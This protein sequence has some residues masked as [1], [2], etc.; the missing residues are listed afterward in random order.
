MTGGLG[1][2]FRKLDFLEVDARALD[3]DEAASVAGIS[4]I[5]S[6]SDTITGLLPLREDCFLGFSDGMAIFDG[7]SLGG[8]EGLVDL[9]V[10][11]G[12]SSTSSSC[13]LFTTTDVLALLV[14]VETLEVAT[15]LPLRGG[16][17]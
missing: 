12:I 9:R 15:D 3:P 5:E 2:P 7:S 6:S 11:A 16:G 13:S 4:T 10:G 8:M 14:M 17:S 1:G